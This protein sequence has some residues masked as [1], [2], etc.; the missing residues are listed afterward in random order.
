M[1]GS[2][3]QRLFTRQSDAPMGA[4]VSIVMMLTIAL[5]ALLFL[6]AIGYRKMRAR[7]AT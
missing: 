5:L 3:I 7:R 4:A 2:L 1:I 6:W